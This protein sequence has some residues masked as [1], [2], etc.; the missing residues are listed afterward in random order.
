MLIAMTAS[1]AVAGTTYLY[2]QGTPVNLQPTTPG[3]QQVGNANI[4]GRVIASSVHVTDPTP[5]GMSIV[6]SATSTTGANFGGFFRSDS[7]MGRAL[8]GRASAM[9]GTTHGVWGQ[10]DS[11]GGRGVTGLAPS[12]TGNATGVWGQTA[13]T[14]GRGVY[15]YTTSASGVN[16]GVMGQSSSPAGFGV[17]SVG[18][19]HATGIISGNGSGLT[20]VNAALLGGLSSAAFGQLATG[21]TWTEANA[22]SNGGNSFTGSGAG[23]TGVNADLLDGLNS[24]AFLQSV[25][26]PLTLSG[27]S[28]SHIIKGENSGTGPGVFGESTAATGQSFGVWGQST[29]GYGVYGLSAGSSGL[30]VFGQASAATGQTI[31]VRGQSD[32]SSGLGVYGKATAATGQTFGVRG[33]SQSTSGYGVFGQASAAT[34]QTFG[35]RGDS[36]STSGYGVYGLATGA[37]AYGVFAGGRLGASGTKSFRIDHPFDPE[38]KYLLHYSAESP[39]VLNMYT[40]NVVTDAKGYATI[41]LPDYFEEINKDPRYTLTVIDDSDDFVIAKV[42]RKV[43]N[44][45]FVIRTNKPSIEVSWEVKAVRNDRWVQKHGAPVEVDKEGLEKGTYQHP[46]LYGLGAERGMSFGREQRQA[47]PTPTRSR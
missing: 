15:G 41:A 13:S 21:N 45:R 16:Y 3:T 37:S 19:M 36:Q 47:P 44:N 33:D 2:G 30:G 46:E 6:G 23:L 12:T 14:T 42:T 40:G 9:S 1:A 25:P 20:G 18:N 35:V 26:N 11:P 24:T 31:G 39:D 43:Q 8:Y 34:G 17:Y 38:N 28:A 5:T 27:T 22:F 7:V 10:A 29:S 32:S 4:S